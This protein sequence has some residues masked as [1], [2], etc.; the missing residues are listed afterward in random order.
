MC[1]DVCVN[2]CVDVC[3][4]VCIVAGL[5]K[6]IDMCIDVGIGMRPDNGDRRVYRNMHSPVHGH[7]HATFCNRP[8]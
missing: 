8:W 2:M 7:V 6:C 5:D 1:V 3:V 4:N